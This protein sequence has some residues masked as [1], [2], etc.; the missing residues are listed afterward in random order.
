M[1]TGCNVQGVFEYLNRLFETNPVLFLVAQILLFIPLELHLITLS[2]KIQ[3]TY[4]S[5]RIAVHKTLKQRHDDDF[6]VQP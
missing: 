5:P 6:N 3:R 2:R 1:I 4:K